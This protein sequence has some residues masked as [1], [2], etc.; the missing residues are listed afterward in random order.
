MQTKALV[1]YGYGVNC[2][3]ESKVSVERAGGTAEIKHIN[4]VID[5]PKLLENYNFLIL[6]GGFSF[7]DD[8]GSGKVFANKMK[9]K[10][11]NELLR[12]VNDG[13]LVA[14]ICN[15]FQ[16]LAKMGL[17]PIPDFEQR[18][19]L[20]VNDS[21]HFEDRW[22]ILKMNKASPCVFTKGIEY[23][24]VP[25]RHGEGKFIPKNE[26]ILRELIDNNLVFAQYVDDKGQL[27]GY[28]W[29]PN[30]SVMNIAGICDKS[31]RVF[32]M[33]PHP[34]AFNEITNNPYWTTGAVKEA[35]GIKLFKN[36][37][38]YIAEKL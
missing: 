26:A 15:G 24:M 35:Q 23:L 30:G 18:V 25:V 36:A 32:G 17:L 10:L 38:D 34:E 21:G 9:F 27:T 20:T 22:V 6:P 1:L 13:K 7:G 33:M 14:G 31:G 4:E 16:S 8:L 2:E 19:T 28:P 3:Q 11:H 12:F 37:V 29:N 5:N